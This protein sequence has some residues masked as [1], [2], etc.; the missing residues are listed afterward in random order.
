MILRK[1]Y[2]VFI[3]YFKIIHMLVTAAI[4]YLIYRST[5][6]LNF[7]NESLLQP[8]FNL[9]N[10]IN[11]ELI[12]FTFYLM[13][14]LIVLVCGIV[15]SVLV[16]K[17]KPFKSYIIAIIS[18]IAIFFLHVLL[19]SYLYEME[20]TLMTSQSISLMRDLVLISIIVQY[21]IVI[22]FIITSIGF[23]IKSFDFGRDL[24]ELKVNEDDREEFEVN[25]QIDVNKTKRDTIRGIRNF[26]YEYL[27]NKF[28]YNVGFFFILIL[29]VGSIYFSMANQVVAI[30]EGTSFNTNNLIMSIEESYITNENYRKLNITEGHSL[31]VLNFKVAS[32]GG[33]P[34]SLETAR[35]NINIG[36]FTFKHNRDYRDRLF[37][38][39][40]SYESQ[41][42]DTDI[43]SFILVF[44]IPESFVKRDMYFQYVNDTRYSVRDNPDNVHVKL[45]PKHLDEELDV[46]VTNMGD[47]M[48]F[49]EPLLHTYL[50]I[51]EFDFGN[52]F[53]LS[54]SY[55]IKENN[56]FS[57]KEYIRPGY[58]S[59]NEMVMMMLKAD[60]GLGENV[61][62]VDLNTVSFLQSFANLRY[63][64]DGS[65]KTTRFNHQVK[66][67]KVNTGNV[68]FMEVPNE[69]LKAT[70]IELVVRMRNYTYKHI[71]K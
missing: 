26:K 11:T 60:F 13:P 46:Y 10:N 45:K 68:V 64:V 12:D 50:K 59:N 65:Y 69:I 42:I 1:P 35:I 49:R 63:K 8:E 38:L 58:N 23:D 17:D 25:V 21:L 66:P 7:L 31:L 14:F 2:A 24:A 9:S 4:I 22:K 20:A 67:V 16:Y 55:C 28:R 57:S 30:S 33:K 32:R 6:V 51:K 5:F 44:E 47:D 37:D 71:L 62:H 61:D 48:Y 54:Y 18:F 29:I 70:E 15:L 43:K 19:D 41:L 3:K 52:E 39:G 40:V 53:A 27:E 36:G 34:Q 56:C